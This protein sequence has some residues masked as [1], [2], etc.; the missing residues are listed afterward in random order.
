[1]KAMMMTTAIKQAKQGKFEFVTDAKVGNNEIRLQTPSGYWKTGNLWITKDDRKPEVDHSASNKRIGQAMA[2]MTA[3]EEPK[4][5]KVMKLTNDNPDTA[6]EMANF[7]YDHDGR[8]KAL[9]LTHKLTEISEKF[10][11]NVTFLVDFQ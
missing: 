9:V 5:Y 4:I 2:A 1:M 11:E 6:V 8:L 10:G 3:I 7:P